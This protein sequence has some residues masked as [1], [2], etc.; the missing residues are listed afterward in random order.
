MKESQEREAERRGSSSVPVS[1][2][3][4]SAL[5]NLYDIM[6]TPAKTLSFLSHHT[7]APPGVPM[8]SDPIRCH[9]NQAEIR[10]ERD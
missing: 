4:S 3:M 10:P 7:G 8:S 1:G 5:S 6:A 2:R 9:G